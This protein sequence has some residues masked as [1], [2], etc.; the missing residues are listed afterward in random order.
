MI[1]LDTGRY[2]HYRHIMTL[3][4]I[5]VKSSLCIVY[6]MSSLKFCGTVVW[7]L[8][9]MCR[10]TLRFETTNSAVLP[11]VLLCNLGITNSTK[12][13]ISDYTVIYSLIMHSLLL[14]IM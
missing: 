11:S 4:E 7:G 13:N 9:S 6:N 5:V 1:P 14:V 10:E 2:I 12:F 3:V 8:A